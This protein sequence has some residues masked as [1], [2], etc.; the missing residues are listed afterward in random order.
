VKYRESLTLTVAVAAPIWRV[1]QNW[2]RLEKF[3]SF[4]PAVREARWV[5]KSRLY[6]REEHDGQESEST[7]EVTVRENENSLSWR[8]LTGAQ[9]SGITVCEPQPDGTTRITLTIEY[10]PDTS[11]QS[12]AA[13]QKRHSAYLQAFKS[14]VEAKQGLGKKS[15]SAAR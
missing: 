2:R 12:P 9:N 5:S 10:D 7:F 4:V 8:S 14:M 15:A 3:P 11:A 1:Y 13:V 6:W